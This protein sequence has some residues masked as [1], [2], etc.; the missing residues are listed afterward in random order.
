VPPAIQALTG[1]DLSD[2][3]N[4]YSKINPKNWLLNKSHLI[5]IHSY[6]RSFFFFRF[7]FPIESKIKRSYAKFPAPSEGVNDQ[8]HNLLNE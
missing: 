4:N 8:E 5:F 1:V 2:V 6:V 3:R 7:L